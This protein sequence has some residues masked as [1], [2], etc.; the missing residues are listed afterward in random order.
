MGICGSSG[1]TSVS[2]GWISGNNTIY[3]MKDNFNGT[4]PSDPAGTSTYLKNGC[5]VGMVNSTT[6][7][8][9]V[10]VVEKGIPS[11]QLGKFLIKY[12]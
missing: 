3:A 2:G 7:S 4:I 1:S 6:N 9:V 10:A 11:K 5:F 8:G 12:L